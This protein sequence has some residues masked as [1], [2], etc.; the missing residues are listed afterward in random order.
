MQSFIAED[1]EI[2]REDPIQ[3]RS[4]V[5]G[6]LD[7]LSEILSGQI[8]SLELRPEF[9]LF[10]IRLQKNFSTLLLRNRPKVASVD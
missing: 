5:W 1:F 7:A 3:P 10:P 8:S 4:I 9:R 2:G 6:G